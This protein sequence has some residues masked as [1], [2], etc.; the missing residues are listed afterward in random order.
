MITTDLTNK[1]KNKFK[2]NP[3]RL[4]M[5]LLWG[6][7]YQQ[8]NQLNRV[9]YQGL[10]NSEHDNLLDTALQIIDLHNRKQKGKNLTFH[11][12]ISLKTDEHLD[13]LQWK[14]VV[15]KHLKALGLS[16]HIGMY[17][18]HKDTDCEHCHVVVSKVNP[19]TMKINT[20]SYSHKKMMDL[21]V[22][23]EK[24]YN[25]ALV[26]HGIG[27]EDNK[28]RTENVSE[29]IE[30][31]TGQQSLYSYI[32]DI[33][34]ELLA[35]KS[36]N[37]FHQ[38]CKE[39]N[40]TVKKS[41]RGL[42]F[43]TPDP[44]NKDKLIYIKGSAFSKKGGSLSLKNLEDILG[45]YEP[46]DENSKITV[47]RRYSAEPVSF[48]ENKEVTLNNSQINAVF[49]EFKEL[50]AENN[51][52][53]ALLK[54]E[55]KRLRTAQRYQLK[56]LYKEHTGKLTKISEI[57]RGLELN[58][59][60]EQQEKE[61]KEKENNLKEHFSKLIAEV[62]EKLDTSKK[63][64]FFDFLQR[65]ELLSDI[66]IITE[67]RLM[68]LSRK[69][70]MTQFY[71][72]NYAEVVPDFNDVLK[73]GI[74]KANLNFMKLAKT[75]SKG[76]NYYVPKNPKINDYIKDNGKNIFINETPNISTIR[77]FIKI[78][79]VRADNNRILL[80]GNRNF[81]RTFL[82][83][84]LNKNLDIQYTD[85]FI[86]RYYGERK[87]AERN[88]DRTIERF[89][90]QF[91]ESRKRA[92]F[93]ADELTRRTKQHHR[94][95]F[96]VKA[97]TVP[98]GEQYTQRNRGNQFSNIK[99]SITGDKFK[100]LKGIRH[101]KK[102]LSDNGGLL[103]NL[104]ERSM[105]R[106]QKENSML[107]HDNLRNSMD[108]GGERE[109]L[110]R[111][112]WEIYPTSTGIKDIKKNFMSNQKEQIDMYSVE[113]TLHTT[114]DDT[115]DV[116]DISDEQQNISD[117]LYKFLEERNSKHALG[118]K[119]VLEHQLFNGQ[120]GKFI[121]RGIRNIDN[122]QYVLLNQ[123]EITYI[124]EIKKEYELKRLKQTK[125]NSE[126]EI[127]TNNQIVNRNKN[128][129]QKQD[130]QQRQENSESNSR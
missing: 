53:R 11:F 43:K 75:T 47:K 107:L 13:D 81:Q 82:E 110:H 46:F 121:F 88:R 25:L 111:M 128:K 92:V 101:K 57:Y 113:S 4:A 44:D 19:N 6:S 23:L 34:I 68:L 93:R 76:M 71:D 80:H 84:S 115:T 30:S 5:Y 74:V 124:R 73:G 52:N 24:K 21:D 116:K 62:K 29:N 12:Q 97:D 65:K 51:H 45:L 114:V 78:V 39:N 98:T 35:C 36:W 49:N 42:V 108:L 105:A 122:K 96:R 26:N 99:Q 127:N 70:S 33:R 17:V 79:E 100:H 83:L 55:L 31:H 59:R 37:E 118:L 125:I 40:L 67:K 48:S 77:D 95:I 130:E 112:R 38:I 104:S 3:T 56:K 15:D 20:L 22:K 10:I 16:E 64:T 89:R 7:D 86:Q 28:T 87:N 120:I 63:F 9:K 66:G 41:G 50:S 123:N 94:P 109:L 90:E 61:Y 60:L 2:D 69:I 18:V 119:D 129:Y 85:Q 8:E 27:T 106:A 91:T 103:Q 72:G 14:D 54:D 117:G 58:Q 126:I 102:P 1:N 32:D